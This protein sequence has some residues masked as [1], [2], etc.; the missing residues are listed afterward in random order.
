MATKID[1]RTEP[2][3]EVIAE[4]KPEPTVDEPEPEPAVVDDPE[5]DPEI[6]ELLVG[7]SVDLPTELVMELVSST[8]AV[9][10]SVSL[11]SPDAYDPLQIL[12]EATGS[13][14]FRFLMVQ[15]TIGLV[16]SGEDLPRYIAGVLFEIP[17]TVA[18]CSRKHVPPPQPW[19]SHDA[20]A[21]IPRPPPWPD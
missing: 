14:E 6:E 21:L 16:F 15:S 17:S 20:S 18:G 7:T 9:R 4:P 19:F 5:L 1:T 3:L 12:L 2:E 11:G 10:I 8:P 13:Q